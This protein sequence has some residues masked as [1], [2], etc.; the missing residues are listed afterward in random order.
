VTSTRT[1]KTSN[2]TTTADQRWQKG[3]GTASRVV[4]VSLAAL[5]GQQAARETLLQNS[6]KEHA[7]VDGKV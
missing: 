5:L 1:P 4:L 2:D 3:G 6:Q 7:D